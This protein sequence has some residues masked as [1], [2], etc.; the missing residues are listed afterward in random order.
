METC[1]APAKRT[2]RRKFKNQIFDISHSPIMDTLLKT[3]SGLMIVLN[4][5]RQIVALNHAFLEAVGVADVQETLGLRLGETLHCVNAQQ[6]PNGCGT[7]P[8][9]VTCGAV[10]ATMAAI[11]DDKTDE[12][13]CVLTSEKDGVKNDI[14][15]MIRAQAITLENNRW[16]LIFAQDITQQQF[17]ANMERVFFHDINNMLTSLLG[18]IELLSMEM[19]GN[20]DVEQI[21][22]VTE[23]LHNEIK[24]QKTLIHYKDAKSLLRKTKASVNDIK[25]ELALIIHGHESLKGKQVKESWPDKDIKIYTDIFMVSKILG[26]M[27]INALEATENGGLVQITEKAG[28][29]HII[30]EVWN[31]S[32]IPPD[33]QKRIFQ[34]HFS[35]KSDMGRGI[36]TFSMK[37]IGEDHLKGKVSFKSSSDQGTI[38][39]FK[40]PR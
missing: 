13:I 6:E 37:L 27:V 11:R 15:L 28:P 26:N 19:P 4:E 33:I 16:I 17:W 10:I 7:T 32:F 2:D 20:K 25:K 1:F 18:N 35:T 9:C 5:D 29:R 3:M 39:T 36:G 12:Q 24:I 34:R 38:F 40:L 8:C 23:R 21:K 14:C 30:W 31:K 22:D